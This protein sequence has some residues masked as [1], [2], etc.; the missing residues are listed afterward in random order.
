MNCICE[1][2]KL[3][4]GLPTDGSHFCTRRYKFIWYN[5]STSKT[6]RKFTIVFI[7]RPWPKICYM[8]FKCRICMWDLLS[9]NA[10][11]FIISALYLKMWL[12]FHTIRNSPSTVYDRLR[13]TL[14]SEVDW[15]V[16]SIK[17]KGKWQWHIGPEFGGHVHP[18]YVRVRSPNPNSKRSK[19]HAILR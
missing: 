4:I 8:R 2:I 10:F 19:E 11:F 1:K 5:R 3:E 9:V 15:N 18:L 14:V 16:C 6:E 17:R 7:T 13:T 12:E